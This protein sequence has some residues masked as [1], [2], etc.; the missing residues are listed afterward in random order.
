MPPAPRLLAPIGIFGGTFDPIHYGHLR[1]ALEVWEALQ[2]AELRLIPA[3]Q[4]PH[5]TT[6]GAS[7]EQRLALLQLA[8]SEQP[9]FRVD[10]RELQRGGPS[11]TVDTLASLRAE[12]PDTPLCLLL[13][14]DA[15][16]KLDTWS[17]WAQLFRLAHLVVLTR[18]G[19]WPVLSSELQAAVTAQRVSAVSELRQQVAGGL[20][21]QAVTP[22]AI[23]ATHIRELLAR[24]QSPRYLLPDT[25]YAFIRAHGIYRAQPSSVN[26]PPVRRA[27]EGKRVE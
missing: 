22:L 7:P 3:R 15:F 19:H 6:P 10:G 25:V 1:V 18:P 5:R 23:S 2:L 16:A 21:F 20:W 9:G 11:Y 8:V 17:R 13:G 12:Y 26:V 24:G 27:T 14:Q 4:P